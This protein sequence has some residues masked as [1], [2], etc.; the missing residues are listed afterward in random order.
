MYLYFFVSIS[1]KLQ[2]EEKKKKK[3][4][5]LKFVLS[6]FFFKYYKFNSW[7]LTCNNIKY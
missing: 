7:A 1:L 5:S 6:S 4:L 3:I 2:F